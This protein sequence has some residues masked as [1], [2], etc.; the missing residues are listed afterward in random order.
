MMGT[1]GVYDHWVDM[2]RISR[3]EV[4][5]MHGVR[6]VLINAV[7]D[8]NLLSKRWLQWCGFTLDS[9]FEMA[10]GVKVRRFYAG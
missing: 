2:L 8:N 5:K 7:W 3:P 10:N 6:P 4:S 9:T 1:P